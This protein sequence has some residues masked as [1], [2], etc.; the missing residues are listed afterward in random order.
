MKY[1]ISI[2]ILF[3]AALSL[4]LL[5]TGGGHLGT[6]F[7][8]IDVGSLFQFIMA[9]GAVLLVTGEFKTFAVILNT[10]F[11]KRYRISAENKEKAVRLLEMLPKVVNYSAVFYTIAGFVFMLADLNDWRLLGLMFAVMLITPM[12]AA[13]INLIL[14][15]PATHIIKSRN[16]ED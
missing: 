10:L 1:A 15:L 3:P 5:L 2:F 13:A 12:Y 16:T 4:P 7:F 14:I 8:F 9:I 11:S 6:L